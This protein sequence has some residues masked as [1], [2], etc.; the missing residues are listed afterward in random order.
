MSKV[1]VIQHTKDPIDSMAKAAAECYNSEPT[2][3]AVLHCLDSGHLSIAEFV[4]FHFRI[5]EVSRAYSHQQVRHRIASYAQRSQRYADEN[6]G[7]I[8]PPSIQ[9]NG[10]ALSIYLQTMGQLRYN[11]AK[12]QELGIPKEDARYI[13]PNAHLT[14]IHVKFNGRTLIEFAHKRLCTRA[15]WEIRDVARKMR[16]A[17]GTICPIISNRMVPSCEHYG[18]CKEKNSCGRINQSHLK[19]KREA[20]KYG[21]IRNNS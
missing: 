5:S 3:T 6:F 15:Q 4:D 18:I 20:N 1:E 14:S 16:D 9:N 2:P 19:D 11:F 8:T 12:L 17:V 7:Y 10:E 13:L 21:T